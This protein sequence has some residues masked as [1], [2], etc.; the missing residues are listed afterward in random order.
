MPF[1]RELRPVNDHPITD[2]WDGILT[3]VEAY[4]ADAGQVFTAI[5][6]LGFANQQDPMETGE[7]NPP[8]CPMVMTIC[9]EPKTVPFEDAKSIADHVKAHILAEAG[10]PNIDVAI[11]EFTTSFFGTSG[12]R[13]P[14]LDPLF[15]GETVQLAHPFTSTLGIPIAPLVNP[16][17]EGT[18]GLFLTRG[19]GKD[20]ILALT[21]AHVVLPPAMF[22]DNELW[23]ESRTSIAQYGL[24][25]LGIDAYEEAL[26]RIVTK[27]GR[28]QSDIG[29]HEDILKTLREQ[30]DRRMGDIEGI[31]G[32]IQRI[33]RN[34]RLARHDAQAFN[35]L[36]SR[37][38]KHMSV[39]KTRAVGHVL[40]ADPI[41][42]SDGREKYT[43]D[44]A[45]LKI[46]EDAFKMDGFLGNT[47][48]I[49]D[50]LRLE[51]RTFLNMMFPNAADRDGYTR[52]EDNL[53]QIRGIVPADEIRV[54]THMNAHGAPAMPV[55]KNGG[56]TGTTVGWLSG[57]KSL[58]RHNDYAEFD[59]DFT[60]RD[61]TIVPYDRKEGAFSAAGDSGSIIIERGGRVVGLLTGGGGRPKVAEVTYATAY[62][63]LE[64]R[65]EEALPGIR[66][67][68][69]VA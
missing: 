36:H 65:I 51:E 54:P 46:R 64:K 28:L 34:V 25:V 24:A 67:Y 44:W 48:Y 1:R 32:R 42:V 60:S 12:P 37:I 38:T 8:F 17:I 45:V 21:A 50:R 56:A 35:T 59:I 3:D 69:Y 15:D 53:L 22:P 7:P 66:L 47:V 10:F 19:G 39:L 20:D 57:L 26:T 33:E 23:S 27:I 41:G 29:E 6:G 68:D 58:V 52:P 18:I 49:G 30:L 2:S 13:L 11:W 43:R 61:L 5:M 16:R 31:A 14:P 55:L 63:E 40:H 4:L 62:C 9:V